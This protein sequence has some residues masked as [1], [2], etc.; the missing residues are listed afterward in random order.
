MEY[1][2]GLFY[3][4]AGMY[5]DAVRVLVDVS[6]KRPK[7]FAIRTVLYR[8]YEELGET[9][10]MYSVLEDLVE[11]DEGR[12]ARDMPWAFKKLGDIAWNLHMDPVAAG[13]YKRYLEINPGDPESAKMQELIDTWEGVEPK[14]RKLGD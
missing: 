4:Q 6:G 9:R 5:E 14:T 12:V 11:I 3:M 8:A 10:R 2:Q 1:Q 13:W 7:D